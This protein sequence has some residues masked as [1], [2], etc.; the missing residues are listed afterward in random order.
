MSYHKSEIS[1]VTDFHSPTFMSGEESKLNSRVRPRLALNRLLALIHHCQAANKELVGG[2]DGRKEGTSRG[3]ES[4]CL[5]A[6]TKRVDYGGGGSGQCHR[7]Q[8][9]F[10]CPMSC[11]H[12][13]SLPPPPPP[14]LRVRLAR[15]GH[16]VEAIWGQGNS[17]VAVRRGTKTKGCGGWVRSGQPCSEGCPGGK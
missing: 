8:W 5:E 16:F 9:V 7:Q 2:A 15:V 6:A 1:I 3:S 14:P 13:R 12:F 17:G 11:R 10:C 4:E